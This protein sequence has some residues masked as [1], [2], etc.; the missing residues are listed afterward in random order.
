MFGRYVNACGMAITPVVAIEL[1][2]LDFPDLDISKTKY[3]YDELVLER[4]GFL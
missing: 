4:F 2:S 1:I 3:G